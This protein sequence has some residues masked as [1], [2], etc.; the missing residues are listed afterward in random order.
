MKKTYKKY[1]VTYIKKKYCAEDNF[2]YRTIRIYQFLAIRA[3]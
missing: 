1:I 2:F 3:L